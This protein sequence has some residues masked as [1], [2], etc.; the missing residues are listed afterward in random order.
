M[1]FTARFDMRIWR[2]HAGLARRAARCRYLPRRRA[3]NRLPPQGAFAASLI[4]DG[5]R[6]SATVNRWR[7]TVPLAPDADIP[8]SSSLR[9]DCRSRALHLL[10]SRGGTAPTTKN[11]MPCH[12]RLRHNAEPQ[13]QSVSR[14]AYNGAD[15]NPSRRF[16]A[17]NIGQ[18][19][20][21]EINEQA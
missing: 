16:V 1:I 6:G 2:A 18:P 21:A 8:P 3:R 13:H 15:R 19:S 7:Y 5:C 17:S 11:Y 12:S 4:S 20:L 10:Y 9:H 14:H